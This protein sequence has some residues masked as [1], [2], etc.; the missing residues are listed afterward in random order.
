MKHISLILSLIFFLSLTTMAQNSEKKLSRKERKE[1]KKKQKE[2]DIKQMSK[3]VESLRFVFEAN[4]IIDRSGK[5]YNADA[6][7]NFVAMDSNHLVFQLGSAMLIGINDVG[8]ITI[9]G[10]ITNTKI[11]K[12]E[13]NGYYYLVIKVSATSGFYE[14]QMDISPSGFATVKVTTSNYKKIVYK[15]NIVT[16]G[17]SNIYKGTTF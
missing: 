14:I 5:V 13:K 11:T 6:T 7:I 12:T 9:E 8:G 17:N 4:E 16:Y 15:G 1:L 10:K 2:E 3:L